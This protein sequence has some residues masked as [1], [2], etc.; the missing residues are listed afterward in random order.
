MLLLLLLCISTSSIVD[1]RLQ[2]QAWYV[3]YASMV[4]LEKSHCTCQMQAYSCCKLQTAADV[5]TLTTT[6]AGAAAAAAV[7]TT[8]VCP[9]PVSSDC[10]IANGAEACLA[11]AYAAVNPDNDVA[12][13]ATDGFSFH[14]CIVNPRYA[15]IMLLS[16]V[17]MNLTTCPSSEVPAQITR[18]VTILSDPRGPRLT[19]DC[20]SLSDR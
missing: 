3:S 15:K 12:C 14:Q 5:T 16:D 4:H 6:T 9:D 19:W 11:A 17:V 2:M 7:N 1:A 18:N 10:L 20:G 8:W 13:P